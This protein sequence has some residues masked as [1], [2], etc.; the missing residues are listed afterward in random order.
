M[1]IGDALGDVV[2]KSLA[3]DAR[4]HGQERGRRHP[5]R[6]VV[7]AGAIVNYIE[8]AAHA[9]AILHST[10]TI[11]YDAPWRQVH[12]LLL[13]AARRTDLVR[14]GPE[15]PFVLQTSLDDSYVSYQINV[16]TD[17]PERML[18]IYS[19]LHANIQDAFNE[20][21]VEIVIAYRRAAGRQHHHHSQG[22]P[23]GGDATRPRSGGGPP[24]PPEVGPRLRPGAFHAA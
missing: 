1:K 14:V 8:A 13:D 20:A 9:H 3:R 21:G 19:W 11:G 22:A 17:R 4:A 7:L 16:H 6:D 18:D 23:A 15:R 10:V 5:E 12:E 24:R 2:L